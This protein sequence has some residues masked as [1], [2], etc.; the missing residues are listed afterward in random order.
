[1]FYLCLRELRIIEY[2]DENEV[3]GSAED[4][5]RAYIEEVLPVKLKYYTQ[6]VRER[7]IWIDFLLIIRTF[8]AIL[9]K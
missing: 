4:P 7:S 1:M 6:Y 3:L 9:R 8:V 2:K 5:E